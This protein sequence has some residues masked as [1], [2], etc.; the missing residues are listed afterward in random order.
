MKY[1][2]MFALILFAISFAFVSCDSKT[3]G[4]E[5]I[6]KLSSSETVFE[7]FLPTELENSAV[8]YLE[9]LDEVTGVALNPKR[10]EMQQKDDFSL[11]IRMPL[12]NGSMIHYRYVK[13]TN[14]D[15]IEHDADGNQIYYRTFIVEHPTVV[16]DKVANWAN[17]KSKY[18]TGEISGF[19]YD[20]KS[21]LPI[22]GMFI[23]INGATTMSQSDG[24]Y[25]IRK[26]PIGEY[27]LVAYHPDDL[28]EPF[29]QSALIAENAVTPASFGLDLAKLVKVTFNVEVPENTFVGAPIRFL[30]SS[31]SFGNIFTE[32]TGGNSIVSSRAPFMNY[33]GDRKYSLTLDLPSGSD[34]RYKYSLGDGFLNAEHSAEGSF[35]TRQLIIPAKDTTIKNRVV[36]WSSK[37]NHPITFQITV[38]KDTPPNEY[39]SIQFNPFVW[40]QPLQMWKTGGNQWTYSLYSPFE[41]LDNSQ[42]RFCRN[43]LCGL[44]D[45]SLTS[46]YDANGY[47]LD[48]AVSDGPR[49]IAYEIQNWKYLGIS[50]YQFE[51]ST[52]KVNKTSFIKGI[53]FTNL[54]DPSW[55]PYYDRGFIDAAVDGVNWVILPSTRMI[56]ST[57]L[58]SIKIDPSKNIS[59]ND[60]DKLLIYAQEAGFNQALYPQIGSDYPTINMFW[61]TISPSYNWWVEWFAQYERFI[62][63]HA[64]YAEHNGISA[65]IIGGNSILPALPSGRLPNGQ[66]SNTPYDFPEKWQSLIEKIRVKY[67]GHLFFAIPSNFAEKIDYPFLENIDT[68]LVETD[69]ALTSSADPAI[70]ELNDRFIKDLDTSIY[71][72]VEK[73]LKPVIIGINYASIDGSASNCIALGSQ[74]SEIIIV[75]SSQD[76]PL[77]LAEQADIYKAIL[78]AVIERD[79]ITGFVSQGYFP[80]AIIRDATSSIR[81]KPAMDVLS[82]Y[83]NE[84]IQL[85]FK[86]QVQP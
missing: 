55:L 78:D 51:K 70:N 32:S 49:N 23:S 14:T 36:S 41:Y 20:A 16:N 1:L 33:L 8:I 48:I 77:D 59:F 4:N 45:D 9:I 11:F 34:L 83:F 44:A 47:I 86:S 54:Y 12:T 38:P 22:P 72:L 81:G 76:I 31:S 5:T 6:Q 71:K 37:P 27:N 39:V 2:K 30:G 85:G 7:V 66:L 43:D 40:M 21:N 13:H 26:I 19:V 18:T 80:A 50:D 64:E 28:Y 53:Q 60:L 67:S 84:I 57:E 58:P 46:G 56:K 3:A 17:E 69:S 15:Q 61:D 24:Y 52:N 79:W 75:N 42:F 62:L 63:D 65:F 29:Q 35:L 68:F 82:Y 73:Y 25:Q 74:C 10:Y